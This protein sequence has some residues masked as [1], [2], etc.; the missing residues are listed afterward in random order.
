MIA[1]VGKKYKPLMKDLT[2][3]QISLFQVDSSEALSRIQTALD[4]LWKDKTISIHDKVAG[5]FD[6][7]ELIAA[8]LSAEAALSS[9]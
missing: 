7:E 6:Y 9:K 5:E 4:F 3:N 2:K 1:D 8:L